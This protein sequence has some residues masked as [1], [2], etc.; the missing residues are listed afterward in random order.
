LAEQNGL[1]IIEEKRRFLSDVNRPFVSH[2]CCGVATAP[3]WLIFY[4][5]FQTFALSPN[6][7]A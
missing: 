6:N 5:S 3:V 1:E 7:S 2:Q 4:Q